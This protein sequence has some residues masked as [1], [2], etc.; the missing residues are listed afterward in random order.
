MQKKRACFSLNICVTEVDERLRRQ[1]GVLSEVC[2][3]T[4]RAT[5]LCWAR[6]RKPMT[7]E[8]FYMQ[9]SQ[10]VHNKGGHQ[11][12]VKTTG[13][14]KSWVA[15]NAHVYC[16]WPNVSPYVVFGRRTIPGSEPFL[17]GVIV[18]CQKKDRMIE[19]LVFYWVKTVWFCEDCRVSS[20][21]PG[22]ASPWC[23]S[24]TFDEGY[25]EEA[26]RR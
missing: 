1:I 25:N 24:E 10:T 23:F 12:I 6:S 15:I 2:N 20:L 5:I 13:N 17:K 26:E 8:F 9:S 4:G 7:L 19:E 16:G 21:S 14:E 3:E 18:Q 11:V 22:H